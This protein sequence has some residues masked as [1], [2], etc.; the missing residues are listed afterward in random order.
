MGRGLSSLLS[1]PNIQLLL[2]CLLLWVTD[3][4]GGFISLPTAS[5]TQQQQC[6]E[7][8][9]QL[10][11][12][13]IHTTRAV[14]YASFIYFN[15]F[16][17]F[18]HIL[19]TSYLVRIVYQHRIVSYVRVPSSARQP[20]PTL[21]KYVFYTPEQQVLQQ[22]LYVSFCLC[23]LYLDPFRFFFVCFIS[24]FFSQVGLSSRVAFFLLCSR[25]R[26]NCCSA[27]SKHLIR[28]PCLFSVWFFSVPLSVTTEFI[29]ISL[30]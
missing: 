23:H 15:F 8:I 30:G 11:V 7:Y 22:Q 24:F 9:L 1:S 4:C 29:C 21:S 26:Y 5:Y 19:H 12:H 18:S 25:T 13:T 6:S 3:V 20:S 16:G 28:L 2:C 10:V 14:Y 17:G 27:Q